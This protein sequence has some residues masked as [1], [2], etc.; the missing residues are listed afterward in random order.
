MHVCGKPGLTFFEFFGHFNINTGMFEHDSD[1]S[2]W[3]NASQLAET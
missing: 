1:A 3:W 2:R